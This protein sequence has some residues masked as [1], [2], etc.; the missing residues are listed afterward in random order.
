MAGKTQG[1]EE[2]GGLGRNYRQPSL[3][4]PQFSVC[5][6]KSW[7]PA[8]SAPTFCSSCKVRQD[9][10]LAWLK[11]KGWLSNSRKGSELEPPGSEPLHPHSAPTPP[12]SVGHE[13]WPA[14]SDCLLD[15]SAELSLSM[16]GPR[17]QFSSTSITK[18]PRLGAY[19]T[20]TH[21]LQVAQA[22]GARS[23]CWQGL[24]L[25]KSVFL[26]CRQPPSF[27]VC[28]EGQISGVS[29]SSYKD[30]NPIRLGSRPDELI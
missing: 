22:G 10:Y 14:C 9:V 18:Y 17:T 13:A 23:Q 4:W 1:G 30:T 20:E 6:G 16:D 8:Q 26:A 24:F 21:L 29:P 2:P 5:K 7:I 25:L 19:T 15:L 12:V 28:T 27:C 3:S 11:S